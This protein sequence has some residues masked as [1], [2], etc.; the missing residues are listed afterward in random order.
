MQCTRATRGSPPSA[1]LA[2]AIAAALCGLSRPAPADVRLPRL[3]SDGMVLQREQPVPVWGWAAPGEVVTVRFAGQERTA[4]AGADGKWLVRLEPLAAAAEP[5]VLAASGS[6]GGDTVRVQDVVVGDVW[7]CAGQSNMAWPLEKALDGEREV[8]EANL[9][10][11]RLF[12]IK[13]VV[14]REPRDDVEGAWAHCTPQSAR[15]FSAVAYFFGREIGQRLKLPVGLVHTSCGWTPGEAWMSREA[16][17][18]APELR[19][20][21]ERWDAI[22]AIY[23]EAKA[24]YEARRKAWEAEAAAAKTAGQKPPPAP[25]GPCDPMFIHRAAGLYNGTVAP[26]APVAMRGVI[27]Y[28]GETNEVRGYQYR[29]LFPALIRDWRR[30]WGGREF[31]FLFVQVANVLPPD[32]EPRASEWAELR[33]SQALALALPNTA[34]AVTIDIG[35]EKDVHPRNKQDVGRRLAL[36]ARAVAYGEKGLVHSGPV[37]ERMAIEG[38]RVR[39]FFRHTGGGLVAR[40]GKLAHFAVAG[41]DRR[42]VWAE[43][44]IDGATVVVHSPEVAKPV[45]VRYAWANNPAGCNLSNREGLPA[46]PFRTDDWTE[47]T[48]GYTVLTVDTF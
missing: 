35:E 7:I 13:S 39:L 45:A 32:P 5:R 14:A 1:W 10:G 40:G 11:L 17:L 42:F 4:R 28:Q 48:R 30:A 24:A 16:L 21:V 15:G 3:F 33:E 38:G 25:R 47:K 27:W 31:P 37:Y 8:A 43:A 2:F 9:P 12:Q 36:A 20:I 22:T 41:D 34:M 26:L 44:E 18:A 19:Y 29:Q 46:A 6:A 23:P